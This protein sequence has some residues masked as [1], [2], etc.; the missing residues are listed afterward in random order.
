MKKLAWGLAILLALVALDWFIRAPDSRSRD[1]TRVIAEQGS[2]E[3]KAYPYSFRVLKVEGNVAFLSTPRSFDVPA[4]RLIAVL[5]PDINTKNANDPAF[6]TAQQTLARIQG[7]AQEIVAAQPGISAVRWK[8]DRDW[9]VG[10]H[11][12]VPD[13]AGP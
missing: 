12:E 6:V 1:L 11:I 10:H 4:A 3:L 13:G 2:A 7:E 9:L 8:L 5:Y